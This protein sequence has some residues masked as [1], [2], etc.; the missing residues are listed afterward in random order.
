[1][2]RRIEVRVPTAMLRSMIPDGKDRREHEDLNES[3]SEADAASEHD[4]ASSV[5]F[6]EA[7]PRVASSNGSLIEQSAAADETRRVLAAAMKQQQ[8]RRAAA[9]AAAAAAARLTAVTIVELERCTDTTGL[10]RWGTFCSEIPN[11]GL[12][13]ENDEGARVLGGSFLLFSGTSTLRNGIWCT[14]LESLSMAGTSGPSVATPATSITARPLLSLFTA[15]QQF[16]SEK[17]ENASSEIAGPHVTQL[18]FVPKQH[19][20]LSGTSDGR[21]LMFPADTPNACAVVNQSQ[22]SL[23][24]YPLVICRG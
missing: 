4:T 18:V 3:D 19:L 6:H 1:M 2:R 24:S 23:P 14:P 8:R 21:V 22:Y 12:S 11:T 20:L 9:A 7:Q 13:H 17:S 10:L 15:L 16:Y 5:G